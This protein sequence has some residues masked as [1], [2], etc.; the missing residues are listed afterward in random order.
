MDRPERER[1][2]C[3]LIESNIGLVVNI[4]SRYP[5]RRLPLEDLVHE[6]I[7]GLIRA[8]REFDPDRGYPFA[9]LAGWWIRK[10]IRLALAREWFPV[11]VPGWQVRKMRRLSAAIRTLAQALGRP[12]RG[13]EISAEAGIPAS[14]VDS[15]L[16]SWPEE[17]GPGEASRDSHDGTRLCSVVDPFAQSPEEFVLLEERRGIVR[18]AVAELSILEQ[19]VIS[20]R[21][22]HG[23][24]EPLT[25][26]TIGG[27]CGLTRQ[28]I[29]Q[30]EASAKKRLR[31]RVKRR[32]C[33]FC[34]SQ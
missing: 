30:I 26:A 14:E 31:W 1:V 10:Y 27:I 23:T 22:G 11:H 6:G 29:L 25:L 7:V 32:R 13:E 16:R 19:V 34:E 12:P 21:F 33:V 8:A 3:E 5:T 18:E 15:L 4:A 24:D 28:R 17:H 20:H 2:I 9:G